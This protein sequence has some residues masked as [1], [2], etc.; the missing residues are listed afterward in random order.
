ME[1][2]LRTFYINKLMKEEEMK[3]YGKKL[4]VGAAVTL[5][6][7]TGMASIGSAEL[8]TLPDPTVGY[9][10]ALGA[11]TGGYEYVAWAHDDFWSY[12]AVNITKAQGLGLIPNSYGNFAMTT[13][14]G[15]LDVIIMNQGGSANPY[16]FE[17]AIKETG[18]PDSFLATWGLGHEGPGHSTTGPVTVGMVL[19]Y[20]HGFN[21]DNNM[22]VF[23]MDMQEAGKDPIGFVGHVY[24]AD[25][26]TKLMIAGYEWAFDENP[27]G[28]GD[29]G[30]PRGTLDKDNPGF[31]EMGD[32]D[33]DAPSVALPFGGSGKLDYIAYAP[34]MDLG[35][36]EID[37]DWLFVVQF[38]LGSDEYPL[39][40][41]QEVFLMGNVAFAPPS[42]VPEPAT[43]LLL[44]LGMVGLA[45]VRRKIRK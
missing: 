11:E 19:D 35:L 41:N 40:G 30:G 16:G 15:V 20:L 6:I 8:L 7:L 18:N 14:S 10:S 5:F 13:G 2:K 28:T 32:Y 33:S 29:S 25:P 31:S 23:G 24:L 9:G 26:D 17:S 34:M 36:D 44:G 42:T 45:G 43:I 21:P 1:R 4:L 3:N 22:P 27:Q 38:E 12:S 39:H 37:P